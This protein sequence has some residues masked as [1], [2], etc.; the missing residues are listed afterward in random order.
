MQTPLPLSSKLI[1]AAY[2][3]RMAAIAAAID[4]PMVVIP[5]KASSMAN[6]VAAAAPA[7]SSLMVHCVACSFIL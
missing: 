7:F 6:R 1:Q 3:A 4:A 2:P 5:P